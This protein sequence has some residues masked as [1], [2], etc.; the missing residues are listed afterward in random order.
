MNKIILTIGIA[1]LFYACDTSE[2]I[3]EHN[4]SSEAISDSL[5][6]ITTHNHDTLMEAMVDDA[7]YDIKTVGIL[8]YDGV[9]D[10]DMMGPMYVLK[11]LWGCTTPTDCT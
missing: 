10:L 8:V 5:P 11:Q 4:K 7:K 1:L 6:E 2:K 3:N 9:N